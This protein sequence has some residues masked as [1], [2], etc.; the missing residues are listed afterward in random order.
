MTLVSVNIISL[1]LINHCI[2]LINSNNYI[3][4][5]EKS[6]HMLQAKILSAI[7]SFRRLKEDGWIFWYCNI[8]T[9]CF[10]C[11]D[12]VKVLLTSIIKLYLIV[13]LIDWVIYSC[14][15]TFMNIVLFRNKD[16]CIGVRSQSTCSKAIKSVWKNYPCH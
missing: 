15:C 3:I 6:V 5:I 2:N 8:L 10:V 13:F 11:E 9:H 12:N 7:F 1:G 16:V 14:N 4:Q